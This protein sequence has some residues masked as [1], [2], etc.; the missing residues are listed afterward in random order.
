MGEHGREIYPGYFYEPAMIPKIAIREMGREEEPN[1]S[2]G[3]L[4][5]MSDSKHEKGMGKPLWSW[6]R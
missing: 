2:M 3:R 4:W 5:G 1:D 6:N